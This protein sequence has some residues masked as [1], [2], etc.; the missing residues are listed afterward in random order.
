M[1]MYLQV[2]AHPQPLGLTGG[3]GHPD[4]VPGA[5][6]WSSAQK[7]ISSSSVSDCGGTPRRVRPVVRLQLVMSTRASNSSSLACRTARLKNLR[8]DFAPESLAKH[9]PETV[10]SCITRLLREVDRKV[11]GRPFGKESG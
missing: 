2:R 11:R 10:V 4:P 1:T 3:Q 7:L 9:I 6:M 8:L 5:G